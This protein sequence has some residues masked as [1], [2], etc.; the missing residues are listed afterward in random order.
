M[1]AIEGLSFR[2][3][4]DR[5]LNVHSAVIHSVPLPPLWASEPYH[6]GRHWEAEFPLNV[7]Q[8]LKHLDP[9][10]GR[11]LL[12]DSPTSIEILHWR[13]FNRRSTI[14]LQRDD[15]NQGV[16]IVSLLMDRIFIAH[17]ASPSYF[18]GMGSHPC[19]SVAR[20][21]CASGSARSK[22]TPSLRIPRR[23]TPCPSFGTNSEQSAF[24]PCLSPTYA[25]RAA[26]PATFT[27][28]SCSPTTSIKG[29]STTSSA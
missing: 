23:P 18:S 15:L 14:S 22:H 17:R 11:A 13:E 5:H 7:T 28:S 12:C 6:G 1:G 26:R 3:L 20:I 9:S 25:C 2:T 29:C 24:K 27:P 21:P 19:D 8:E 16:R 10:S 4:V